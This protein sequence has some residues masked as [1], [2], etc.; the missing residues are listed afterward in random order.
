MLVLVVADHV[1]EPLMR[2]FVNNDEFEEVRNSGIVRV[3]VKVRTDVDQSR[4][5][6]ST[7]T[8]TNVDL[9]E[10]PILRTGYGPISPL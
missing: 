6:N 3:G 4:E 7:R 2:H 5:F 9:D 1:V 10:D 8:V